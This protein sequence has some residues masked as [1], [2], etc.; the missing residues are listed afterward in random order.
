MTTAPWLAGAAV[1]AKDVSTGNPTTTPPATTASRAIARRAAG[2]AGSAPGQR[3]PGRQRLSARADPMNSGDS[4]STATRV[5]GTVNENAAL[6]GG[7]T[8][9]RRRPA[10]DGPL[11]AY[12]I[13]VVALLLSLMNN[14]SSSRIASRLRE[15][16]AGAA[17]GSRL[18]S[19]R[20]LVAE[21]QASP[22]TVQKALQALTPEGAYREPAGRAGHSSAPSGPR[23]P[24]T[25]AGRPRPCGHRRRLFGPL[26]RDAARTERRHRVPFRLSGPRTPARAAGAGGAHAGPPGAT[27]PC[28]GPRRRACPSCSPGSRTNSEAPRRPVSPRRHRATSSCFP[29][30]QSGLSSIFT[31]LVG[32]GQPLLME[33]PTYWGAILAA[34]QAGVRVIPV[35]SGAD[36][37]DPEELARAFEETRRTVVL[38]PAELR[39]PHRRAV[40]TPARRAGPGRRAQKRRVPGRGRLGPR[41]RHHHRRPTPR[42]T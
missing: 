22:V 39:E 31:A 20:S 42:R 9:F 41:F 17:P 6:P 8:R 19:T 40:G 36:G 15:W 33:S 12:T 3:Q 5:S 10:G 11:A 21:Y 4:P 29:G 25:T 16:I 18:P 24:R 26:P 1:R 7:P 14:D 27:P 23:G 35:P 30:S 13:S 32:H 34:A 2:A 38:R 37:P 28:P